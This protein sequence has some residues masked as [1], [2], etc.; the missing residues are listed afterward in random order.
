MRRRLFGRAGALAVAVLLCSTVAASA[1]TVT[2]DGDTVTPGVQGL[3]DLGTAA[4]GEDIHVDVAFVL[5]CS[6]MIH[7]D[8]GQSVRLTPGRITVPVG[9]SFGVGSLLFAPPAGWP[10]DGA[11]CPADLAPMT[12]PPLHMIVTA[13]GDVG[14]GYRY[15]FTWNRSLTPTTADD[16]SVF[17]GPSTTL[18]FVLDVATN[19]PPTL[20]LP[21]DMTVEGDTTGGAVAA[22]SVSATDAED[23]VAPIPNC[24]PAAGAVLPLGHTVVNCSVTDAGGLSTE[25]SFGIT[26][27]DTTAPVL[28]HLP[29]DIAVTTGNPAGAEVSWV[30]PTAGDVVDANPAVG[31]TPASGTTFPVGVSTVT[32]TASDASGNESSRSFHVAVTFVPPVAW[33]TVWGEPVSGGSGALVVNGSR[34]VPVKVETFANGVE[35]VTGRAILSVAPCT[36]G[37]AVEIVLGRDGG[38]WT[39]KLDTSAL[40]GTGCYRATLS[41]DGNAA[42]S[43]TLDVRGGSVGTATPARGNGRS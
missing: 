10:A 28:A 12:S 25:G 15:S 35:Q 21:A 43:F 1:E 38:R 8:A 37:S 7:V 34:S 6:G 40:G 4:P 41:L 11:A 27:V 13:P 9:G 19:T 5:A 3:I 29:T 20:N 33:S 42:G 30:D 18:V 17:E 39:G 22:Y 14:V 2:A 24:G 26:V 36:G 31:C 16:A 32:C 23:A